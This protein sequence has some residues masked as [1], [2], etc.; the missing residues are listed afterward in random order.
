MTV[1]EIM[2]Q[3]FNGKPIRAV[4]AAGARFKVS[5]TALY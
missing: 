2:A 4:S 5:S 1:S 3:L